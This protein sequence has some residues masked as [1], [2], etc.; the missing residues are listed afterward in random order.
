MPIEKYHKNYSPTLNRDME[1]IV[2]GD[3][4]KVCF[5]IPSQNGRFFD[6]KNF[7][8]IEPFSPWIEKGDIKL[9]C[10][11]SIDNETWSDENKNP[12][13]RIELHER[14]FQYIIDE[15]VP[16]FVPKGEKA[17]VTGCSMGAVHSGI[18]FFR[19]PDIF[20]TILALSGLYNAQYFFHE[21]MDGLVYDNSPVHF[22]QNMPD[23]H[24]WLELYRK[25]KIIACVGQGAYEDDLLYGTRELDRILT[26]KNIPHQFD[27]WGYD[28]SHDWYWWKKQFSYF[29]EQIFDA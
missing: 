6:F 24:P 19:R 13:N 20:N 17:M 21:Y 3:K 15:L 12:K 29:L 2:F 5:V 25:S 9:V 27:Y 11:D 28:V 18:L 14:W 16:A 7:G 22:L 26:Q 1:S 10:I 23:N 4:G 8:M